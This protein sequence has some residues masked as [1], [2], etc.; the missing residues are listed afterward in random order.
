MG[1]PYYIAPEVWKKKYS[2]ES[3]IWSCGVI[4]YIML[5]GTPPFNGSN[6]KEMKE[7]VLE[8]KYK[9]TDGVWAKV[10][11]EAKDLL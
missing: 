6:D 11:E 7:R 10:S 9:I 1:T 4:M 3:D 5:C 2:I 8:G